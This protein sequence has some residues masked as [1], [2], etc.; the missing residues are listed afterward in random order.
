MTVKERERERERE[1]EINGWGDREA[2]AARGGDRMGERGERDNIIEREGGE[3][4][5]VEWGP[6]PQ[7]GQG[8]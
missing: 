5:Q 6:C 3:R 8:T 4:Q 1:R 7:R 2:G